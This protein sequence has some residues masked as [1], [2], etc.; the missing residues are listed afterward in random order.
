MK[1]KKK[2][3]AH[4]SPAVVLGALSRTAKLAKHSVWPWEGPIPWVP[5]HRKAS[6]AGRKASL[7]LAAEGLSNLLSLLKKGNS[8]SVYPLSSLLDPK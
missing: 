3:T 7:C 4:E 1:E 8:S 2:P 6:Y 5:S